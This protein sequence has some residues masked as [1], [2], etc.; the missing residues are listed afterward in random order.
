MT[1]WFD[2]TVETL[3]TLLYC[4]GSERIEY[5]FVGTIFRNIGLNDIVLYI[6]LSLMYCIM[7]RIKGWG[8]SPRT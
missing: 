5:T 3:I 4:F 8:L 6:V 2:P 7:C 1:K